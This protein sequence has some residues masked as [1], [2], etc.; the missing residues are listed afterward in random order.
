MVQLFFVSG[1]PKSGTTW[2]QRILDAHPEVVCSGEGHF[3]ELV[4]RP[5]VKLKADFNAKLAMDAER[6]FEGEPYYEPLTDAEVAPLART[7]ILHV[8]GKRA[9][10]L[11]P[12]AIG[13]KTPRYTHGLGS[14][15][16]LFP[17]ARFVNIVRN[18]YDVAVSMLHHAY[19]F[20]HEDA[21]TL[22]TATHH[23]MAGNSANA[24]FHAQNY[25][26]EFTAANPGRL[27]QIRYEDLQAEGPRVMAEVFRFIEVDD[28]GGLIEAALAE[29][30]FEKLS[31]RKAGEENAKSFFR[32]GVVGDWKGRLD[33]E[34]LRIIDERC[35][36][37]MKREGYEGAAAEAESLN[38]PSPDATCRKFNPP[39][40]DLIG[41]RHSSRSPSAASKLGRPPR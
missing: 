9:K 31:G 8:M 22:G 10:G 23:T 20:G 35:G 36:N 12:K 28:A 14:L 21:L 2:L 15:S 29:S 17:K 24:W 39:F 4:V 38:L 18:P 33:D 37:L 7:L 25:V 5:L 19:R 6:V 40:L 26:A 27:L 11:E 32:K 41:L 13:D 34:A 30:D 16:A 1:A 3:V